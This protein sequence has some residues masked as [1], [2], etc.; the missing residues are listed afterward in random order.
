MDFVPPGGES[1]AML[2]DRVKPWLAALEGETFLVAHGGVARV[3]LT[4]LAGVSTAEAASAPIWQ[5]RA[6]IFDKGEAEWIG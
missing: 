4:L 6:L 5:G 2:V 3:C 1:Y